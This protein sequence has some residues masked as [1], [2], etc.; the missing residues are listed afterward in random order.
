M[1]YEKKTEDNSSSS[2][3]SS[4]LVFAIN[5][6]RFEIRHVDPSITLLQ[7][8]RCHTSFKSA[9]LSCGEGNLAT[10]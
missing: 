3:S 2:S 5:N 10:N 4:N 9:K 7:F 6:K 1:D 8:L